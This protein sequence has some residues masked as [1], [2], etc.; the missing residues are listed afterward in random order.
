[1]WLKKWIKNIIKKI[2]IRMVFC[3]E[4][5]GDIVYV[6]VFFLF[7]LVGDLKFGRII[8]FVVKDVF[9][10]LLYYFEFYLI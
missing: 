5:K 3:N 4:K 9:F 7:I 6:C 8:I 1:M 2:W 10:L